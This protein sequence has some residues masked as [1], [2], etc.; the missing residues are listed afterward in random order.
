MQWLKSRFW[1]LRAAEW[2]LFAGGGL[3][4]LWCTPVASLVCNAGTV[5]GMGLGLFL[6]LF[7]LFFRPLWRCTASKRALRAALIV[8]CAVCLLFTSVAAA[9]GG[10]MV[11]AA[12][13]APRVGEEATLVV[14]GCYVRGTKV[15]KSLRRRLE[16]ALSYLRENPDARAVL[17]GGQGKG[18]DITEAQA[19]YEWLTV[20]GI[21]GARLYLED[22]SENTKQNLSNAA[23]IIAREN[24]PRRVVIATQFYH[25]Y[26]AFLYAKA[27]G[28]DPAA[29]SAPCG[30]FEAPT[31][32]IREIAGV[33]KYLILDR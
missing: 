31:Y 23:Q 2:V 20:R 21:D 15:E 9:I 18:E 8:F 3:L 13:T 6:M 17:C 1:K 32:F 22:T 26:R 5:L 33:M 7:A 24:L 12:F 28:L 19:E 25:E 10:R 4:F 11:A 27:A 29:K 30:F 14:L 16:A